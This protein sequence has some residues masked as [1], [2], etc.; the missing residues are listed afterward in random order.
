MTATDEARAATTR[1]QWKQVVC[2]DCTREYT[3]TPEDDY[4][5]YERGPGQGVC[6]SCLL[7]ENGLNPETTPLLVVDETGTEIDPRDNT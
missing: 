2:R 6:T 7:A 4:Y 5:G 1:P 3:C